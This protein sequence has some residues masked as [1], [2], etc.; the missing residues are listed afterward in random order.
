[1]A[2]DQH[3]EEFIQHFYLNLQNN[4]FKK[5]INKNKSGNQDIHCN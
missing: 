3:E 1:M 4:D 5:D 2:K